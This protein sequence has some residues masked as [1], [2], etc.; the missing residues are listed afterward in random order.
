MK[1]TEMTLEQIQALSLEDIRGY[2]TKE[3]FDFVGVY[4]KHYQPDLNDAQLYELYHKLIQEEKQ[5]LDKA[6]TDKNTAEILDA[7]IDTEWVLHIYSHTMWNSMMRD[8]KFRI[9]SIHSQ[10]A[11]NFHHTSEKLLHELLSAVIYSN[12]SKSL[13]LEKDGEKKGKIIKG[14]NFKPMEPYLEEIIKE[15]NLELK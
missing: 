1:P 13:E 2:D 12:Y 8:T 10:I 9:Q 3:L 5:E 4:P 15:H 11:V 14:D 7:I 6:I